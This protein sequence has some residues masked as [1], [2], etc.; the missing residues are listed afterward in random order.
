MRDPEVNNRLLKNLEY[1]LE[2][3]A[4]SI[5]MRDKDELRQFNDMVTRKFKAYQNCM[6]ESIEA[7]QRKYEQDRLMFETGQPF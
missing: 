5:G 2:F 4:K 1:E 7:P 3:I 6:V